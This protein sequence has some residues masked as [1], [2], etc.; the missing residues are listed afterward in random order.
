MTVL[1]IPTA[2]VFQ[3]L[4]QPSRYKAAWGGR[5]SGKSHFFAGLLI[6][7]S[8]YHRG[9]LSLCVR[10]IQKS[11]KHSAKRL[12]EAKLTE[13]RL[14]ETDGFKIFNDVIQTPGDGIMVFQ[15]M[16]DHTADS[17]KSF[18]GFKRAWIEEAQNFSSRSLQLLRPTIRADDSEIWAS[19]NPRLKTDPIDVLFR[20][21][22]PPTGA[23]VQRANWS[24]NPWF[25]KVLEQ[26]RIDCKKNDPDNYPH[27]WEGDY[28]AVTK[29]AY[30]ARYITAA[31]N[32]G[33]IS[34]V[35]RNPL[36][37]V[38]LFIDIGGTGAK[39]DNFVIW[40]AQFIGLQIR[41]IDHYEV[42]GQPIEHHLAW[43]RERGYTSDKAKIYLPHD[44]KTN[45]RVYDVSYESEFKR[46]GYEVE[47]VPNQGK[48]AAAARIE[49]TRNL[50]PSIWLDSKRCD[51]GIDAL[52]WYHEKWDEARD[53]GLGPDHD[54]SSHSADAFGLMCVAYEE[55][56][57]NTVNIKF[58]GWGGG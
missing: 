57:A 7:D 30:Y 25:P 37:T 43:L 48:G 2:R 19:W 10:E 26:E 36:H 17:I 16:Q 1:Q 14:S 3:P 29:G 42:Q 55:P 31:R 23:I 20:R 40:A 11:L 4:L 8:L 34:R 35:E 53:I 54:W 32:E 13:M 51:A 46:A 50:W 38:R 56:T 27:I 9:L 12:I 21:G 33:R 52:A 22:E 24:D 18:E 49:R 58:D 45:D 15:G 5:G 44:G 47:V 39:S 28:V 6:D 41:V